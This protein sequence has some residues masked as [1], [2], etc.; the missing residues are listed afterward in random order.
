MRVKITGDEASAEDGLP[1]D[2]YECDTRAFNSNAV[3]VLNGFALTIRTIG[4]RGI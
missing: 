1:T 2:G 4:F 3:G